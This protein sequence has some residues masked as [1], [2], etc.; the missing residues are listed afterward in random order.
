MIMHFFQFAIALKIV[1]D[2]HF[3]SGLKVLQILFEK[4][5]AIFVIR[6]TSSFYLVTLTEA[7]ESFSDL[8][9]SVVR[10]SVSLLIF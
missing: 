9:L 10:S 5:V 4:Q 6:F 2:S 7:R 1:I 8:L 3:L